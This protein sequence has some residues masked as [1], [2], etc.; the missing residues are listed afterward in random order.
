MLISVFTEGA[1]VVEIY[2]EAELIEEIKVLGRAFFTRDLKAGYYLIK[3]RDDGASVELCVTSP[4]I[5][6]TVK[7]GRITVNADAGDGRSS[8]SF[9]DFR[10]KGDRVAS[11]VKCEELTDEE[12]KNGVITREIPNDAE[13]FKVYFENQYG[14]WTHRM[15]KIFNKI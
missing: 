5:T 2:R 10:K 3:L 12:K 1:D 6:F 13:N 15:I 4:D 8:L 9:M 14:V 11:L 7:D